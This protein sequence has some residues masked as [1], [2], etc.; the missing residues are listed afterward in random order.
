MRKIRVAAAS[1][2]E[3]KT[4]FVMILEADDFVSN[5]ICEFVAAN[6]ESNGWCIEQGYIWNGTSNYMHRTIHLTAM[7]GSSS[8]VKVFYESLPKQMPIDV[9]PTTLNLFPTGC[10]FLDRVHKEMRES[11]AQAG[12]PIETLPFPGAIYHKGHGSNISSLYSD[13]E[14]PPPAG[15]IAKI[16]RAARN[17]FI[18]KKREDNRAYLTESIK[19]EFGIRSDING[20][21]E[22]EPQ[23]SK[24]VPY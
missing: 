24:P 20:T 10:P 11:Q 19:T 14:R 6:R 23:P 15:L 3:Y 16:R 17:F 4:D 8:I 2:H 1:L 12:R 22:T 5:R 7:C 21:S 9:D 18:T 13:E